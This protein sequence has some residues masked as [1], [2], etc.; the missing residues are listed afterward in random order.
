[1]QADFVLT[2]N[3]GEIDASHSWNYTILY[4]LEQAFLAAIKTIAVTKLQHHWPLYLP[5]E[6]RPDIFY[7]FREGILGKLTKE[8]I[9][10]AYSKSFFTPAILFYVPDQYLDSKGIPLTLSKA[11]QSQYISPLYKPT[12]LPALKKLGVKELTFDTFLSHLKWLI[13]QDFATFKSRDNDWHSKLAAVLASEIKNTTY[14]TR[15][16]ELRIIPL[17]TGEWVTAST[18]SIFFSKNDSDFKA[19][20]GVE[21]AVVDPVAE[22]DFNQQRLLTGLGVKSFD[23][24]NVCQLILNLHAVQTNI[25]KLSL[26]DLI[27][28]VKFLYKSNWIPPQP[29]DLWFMAES[30]RRQ[31]GSTLYID[32]D[33]NDKLSATSLFTYKRT[34]VQF[35][36][37]DYISQFPEQSKGW[38]SWLGKHF[39]LSTYPRLVST[40]TD[41]SFSLSP[42]FKS[43]FEDLPSADILSLLRNNWKSYSLWI[44]EGPNDKSPHSIFNLS[45]KKLTAALANMFVSCVDGKRHRLKQTSLPDIDPELASTELVF[46]LDIPDP[47]SRSWTELLWHLGVSVELN[48]HFYFQCIQNVMSTE[49]SQDSMSLLYSKIQTGIDE[50]NQDLR[51]SNPTPQLLTANCLPNTGSLLEAK[52]SS[53]SQHLLRERSNGSKPKIVFGTRLASQT[54]WCIPSPRS[55]PTAKSCSAKSPAFAIM[56][57]TYTSPNAKRFT[58][59]ARRTR[60]LPFFSRLVKFS[61]AITR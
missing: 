59:R 52:N 9:V 14:N 58:R 31:K 23:T 3:R 35:L 40:A 51:Y 22:A 15:V 49:V 42:D 16:K 21:M 11:T 46:T 26:E 25:S 27:S 41:G 37:T 8:Y 44:Q 19:P 43:L 53:I 28:Q 36:H 6:N 55:I 18:D 60:S 54:P 24:A 2:A 39:G 47:S 4:H 7:P 30:G 12:T 50:L 34:S 5:L 48:I 57:S 45:R 33:R 61:D 29:V 32:T 38:K 17:R 20:G 56:K 10:Q 13:D 1:M